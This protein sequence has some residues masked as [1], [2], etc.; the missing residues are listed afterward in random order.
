MTDTYM[1]NRPDEEEKSY[2]LHIGV[3]ADHGG[4]ELKEYLVS[5][6]RKE[7]FEVTDFGNQVLIPGD[8]FPDY[9]I[10]LGLAVG[11]G[12]VDRGIAVCGS[13]VGANIIA[14][15][16]SGVRASL[17]NETYSAH[18]GV[19]HDNM[20]LMCLGGRVI[21]QALAADLVNTFLKA[22]Y[23]NEEPHRR[24]VQKITDFENRNIK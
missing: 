17:I 12:N 4:F 13:G 18:Q 21:G 3:A 9:V 11:S 14:N 15:K 2:P 8:D 22:K 19:E 1:T 5:E 6:L 24:R 10:P 7:G 20:N 23:S 16:I